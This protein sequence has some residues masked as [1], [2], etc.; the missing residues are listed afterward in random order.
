MLELR[1]AREVFQFVG[2][3]SPPV[4]SLLRGF[5]APVYLDVEHSD[6]DLA[7][8]MA[9]DGDLFNRWE[10]GQQ[11]ALRLI[12][13]L[14]ADHAAGRSLVVSPLL[15]RAF[16]RLLEEAS[17]ASSVG[18]GIRDPRFLAE[19]L[20][21]PS[22]A[23]LSEHVAPIDPAA[24]HL[25]RRF[26]R[27]SLAQVLRSAFL[28][29]YQENA[30]GVKPDDA[31]AIGQR[32]LKNACLGYLME[33]ADDEVRA[34][35]VTQFQTATNMTD[36]MAALGFLVNADCVEREAALAD[37]YNRWRHYP[38]VL[39]KWF[40]LQAISRLPGTLETVKG[41]LNHPD[42]RITNPNKVYATIGAFCYSNPSNFHDPSG[43]G[44][45][46]LAE[47]VLAIDPLNPQV[48]SRLIKAL[49]D[50]RRYESVRRDGM[51]QALEGILRGAV[52]SNDTNEIAVKSLGEY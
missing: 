10:A 11:L 5:S 52:L 36:A 34:L 22:E 4:P 51:R 28:A 17:G 15:V 27:T 25:V 35:C 41:L 39:D 20:A 24:I 2:V 46:F 48:A 8:L 1:E 45:V 38:I 12:K 49:S 40:S 32:R 9:E 19:A 26:L 33:L 30:N 44:Y 6:D 37:F 47:Q 29:L 50:W 13:G 42:F 21:I 23:Y 16:G 14:L 18:V 7:F 31:R 3:S 43:V